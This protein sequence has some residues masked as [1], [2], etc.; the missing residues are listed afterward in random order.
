M[1]SAIAIDKQNKLK[2]LLSKQSIKKLKIKC[3]SLKLYRII[4]YKT[5]SNH[6]TRI[7][8]KK[9]VY[10]KR[11]LKQ[12]KCDRGG[13]LIAF[14]FHR[15]YVSNQSNK[16][17]CSVINKYLIP[18]ESEGREYFWSKFKSNKT[19]H[20]Y[21]HW[22]LNKNGTYSFQFECK[23]QDAYYY[24]DEHCGTWDY[25]ISKHKLLF[26]GSGTSTSIDTS[27]LRWN[28]PIRFVNKEKKCWFC[29]GCVK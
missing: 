3:E 13:K 21:N 27:I 28:D 20:T 15:K 17:I 7:K 11:N 10:K 26:T 6:G 14:Y 12:L 4:Q 22:R 16:Y 24:R 18:S 29:N 9:I 1:M 8:T 23:I 2:R 25:S 19:V 5:H